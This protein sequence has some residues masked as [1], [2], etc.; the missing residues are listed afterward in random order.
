MEREIFCTEPHRTGKVFIRVR[1][2]PYRVSHSTLLLHKSTAFYGVN[3]EAARQSISSEAWPTGQRGM[4][5][6]QCQQQ[7]PLHSASEESRLRICPASRYFLVP[8]GSP[9]PASS[10]FQ[11][12]QQHGLQP[13]HNMAA[14]HATAN[15]KIA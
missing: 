2:C 1:H 14:T 3:G 5:P 9:Q 12:T 11:A 6:Q 13:P 10:A 8:S 15:G 7:H 4:V